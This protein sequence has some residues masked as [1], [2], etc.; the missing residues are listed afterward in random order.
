V[1]TTKEL[2]VGMPEKYGIAL[3]DN[4]RKVFYELH[5]YLATNTH[6]Y[7]TDFPSRVSDKAIIHPTAYIAP[8]NV[9]IGD[10]V[11][12][13]PNAVI[14][15]G[16]I[17]EDGAIIRAGAT[18]SA[19]GF[20]FKRFGDD[21]MHVVH[22]G[23][24]HLGKRVE[25]QCN[26]N[27]DR[28][29]FGGYTEVGDDTKI[30]TLVHVGHCVVLGRRCFIAALTVICGST[31]LGDDVWVGPHSVISSELSIGQGA[32]IT[33]GSVVTRDVPPRHRVTGNFAIDHDKFIAFL[34]TVR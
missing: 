18:I 13:E 15:E 6:F 1:I 14:L 32:H 2:A 30:D 23:G 9:V 8:S 24:A 27:V 28:A 25:V 19:E 12:I 11:V 21:V 4:S 22:A 33:L 7:W 20:E 29:V 17:I 5:N 10:D 26:S 3:S 16:A 34:K 31:T